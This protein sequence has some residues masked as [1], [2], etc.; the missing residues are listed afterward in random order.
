MDKPKL[1]KNTKIVK[2]PC[3][4]GSVKSALDRALLKAKEQRWSKVI[5]IGAGSERGHWFTTPMS[6]AVAQG[7]LEEVKF[8]MNKDYFG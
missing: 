7:M 5:I 8:L 6:N 2:L 1:A 3:V 4:T